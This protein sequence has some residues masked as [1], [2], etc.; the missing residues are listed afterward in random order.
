MSACPLNSTVDSVNT[1]KHKGCPD[2]AMAIKPSAKPVLI[3]KVANIKAAINKD[4]MF[5][6][7][8]F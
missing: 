8:L 6:T 7:F 2:G 3:P 5:I 4:F 1:E